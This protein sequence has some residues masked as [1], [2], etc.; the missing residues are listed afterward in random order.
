MVVVQGTLS[1]KVASFL[2]KL[3]GLALVAEQGSM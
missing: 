2:P 3:Q 1:I